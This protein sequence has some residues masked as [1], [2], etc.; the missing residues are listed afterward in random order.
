MFLILS[1]LSGDNSSWQT[2]LMDIFMY[3]K[4]TWVWGKFRDHQDWI[5]RYWSTSAAVFIK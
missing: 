2:D 5:L 3:L 4:Y 1:S